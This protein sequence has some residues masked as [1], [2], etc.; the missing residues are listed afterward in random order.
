MTISTYSKM[1]A[2]VLASAVA[3]MVLVLPQTTRAA[4][5]DLTLT[6]GVDISSGGVSFDVFGNSAVIES[7][8]VGASTFTL[9]MPAGSTIAIQNSS[10][11]RIDHDI[12]ST[13]YY[14]TYCPGAAESRLTITIPSGIGDQT[15]II[16]PTTTTCGG[17][18]GGGSVTTTTTTTPTPTTTTTT[19]TETTTTTPASDEA[20]QRAQLQ[21]QINA[22]LVQLNALLAARGQ[23]PVGA[24]ANA[25][26]NRDLETGSTGEDVRALQAWLN[27]NGYMVASTGAGSPGN[28]TTMFGGLTRA[29]LIKYQKAMGITPAVGYF[30]PKTRAYIA[31]NP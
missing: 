19:T 26:F 23:A 10:S 27:G 21:A 29:A 8:A 11:Y 14:S 24:N 2:L 25:S 12:A 28:E 15:I 30:G 20:T 5:D 4:F 9:T 18:G 31:A 1:A 3:A 6:T 7:I 22:L 13:E 17:G 16:T